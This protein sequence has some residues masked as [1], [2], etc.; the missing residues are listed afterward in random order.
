MFTSEEITNFKKEVE[1]ILKSSI[2]E[3]GDLYS[4]WIEDN[5]HI[6][7]SY[8]NTWL[9]IDIDRGIIFSEKD[10][11]LFTEKIK[12]IPNRENALVIHTSMFKRSK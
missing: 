11:E 7:E 1:M 5:F 8:P 12:I 2:E 4:K 3:E 9:A 10:D 6:I